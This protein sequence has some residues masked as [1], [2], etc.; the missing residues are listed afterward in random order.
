MWCDVVWYDLQQPQLNQLQL[1]L[2]LR[3]VRGNGRI[4]AGNVKVVVKGVLAADQISCGN[5][6]LHL[7]HGR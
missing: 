3:R 1:V 5:A 2:A 4:S 6:F 7:L